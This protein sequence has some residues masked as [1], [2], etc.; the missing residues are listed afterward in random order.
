VLLRHFRLE[1]KKN[2]DF[3]KLSGGMKRRLLLCRALVHDPKILILDEPTA[4]ADLELRHHI[5]NYLQELN[6]DGKTIFLT[7]HYMEEAEKLSKTIM[8]IDK[9]KIV[10]SGTKDALTK[11]Q[12]LE[13]RFLE[14]TKATPD[15]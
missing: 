1:D 6:H 11:D 14:L 12:S 15:D 7:T 5:W 8:I 3:R 10:H 9:G 2:L 13:K 4:G